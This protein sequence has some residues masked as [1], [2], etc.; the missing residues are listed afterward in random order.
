MAM[1]PITPAST[2]DLVAYLL[3]D[4][5]IEID[6]VNM[7][8]LGSSPNV[9]LQPLLQEVISLLDHPRCIQLFFICIEMLISILTC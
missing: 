6:T 8:T 7:V 2:L 1:K 4:I 5:H 3:W 9:T